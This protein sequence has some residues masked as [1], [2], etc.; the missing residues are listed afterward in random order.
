MADL[1]LGPALPTVA[2]TL[3]TVSVND[4]VPGEGGRR[5]VEGGPTP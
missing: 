1:L 5:F 2:Q 3:L 4:A